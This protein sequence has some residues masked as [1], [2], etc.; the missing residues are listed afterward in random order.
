VRKTHEIVDK[1]NPATPWATATASGTL[2]LPR[3]SAIV[4]VGV[5]LDSKHAALEVNDAGKRV[6][7]TAGRSFWNNRLTLVASPIV[8]YGPLRPHRIDFGGWLPQRTPSALAGL[9]RSVCYNVLRNAVTFV[10][11]MHSMTRMGS[12]LTAYSALPYRYSIGC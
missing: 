4:R 6:Q 8:T 12:R 10:L 9:P 7:L 11:S 5:E 1:E 2:L 3:G